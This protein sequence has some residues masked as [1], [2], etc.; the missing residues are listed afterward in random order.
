MKQKYKAALLDMAERFGETSYA[1]RLKVGALLY[2]NDSIIA[3]GTNGQP[4]KWHTEVCEGEDGKT[5]STVRHAEEACLQKLWN[6]HEIAEGSTMFISHSPCLSC[7]IKLVTAGI[8]SIVYK[9]DYRC[10]EGLKYLIKNGVL[11]E[12]LNEESD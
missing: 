8:K 4:P 5:L 10:D 11:V 1:N 9:H 6:S 7:S 2:K 12:K 3:L